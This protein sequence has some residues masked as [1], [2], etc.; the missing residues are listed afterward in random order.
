M[1][2]LCLLRGFNLPDAWLRPLWTQHRTPETSVL[3]AQ[4]LLPVYSGGSS[5]PL[6]LDGSS[7]QIFVDPP[8]IGQSPVRHHLR[9]SAQNNAMRAGTHSVHTW[10]PPLPRY[11]QSLRQP[12]LQLHE[13]ICISKGP[14]ATPYFTGHCPTQAWTLGGQGL[15]S[16]CTLHVISW[17]NKGLILWGGHWQAGLRIP[18]HL[19]ENDSF[20]W[21]IVLWRIDPGNP[22]PDSRDKTL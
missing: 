8:H 5:S 20:I 15:A 22:Q 13:S 18:S 9:F 11:S 17:R 2:W 14:G 16:F 19:L 21:I 10:F 7:R 1:G 4:E 12:N 6:L 3:F